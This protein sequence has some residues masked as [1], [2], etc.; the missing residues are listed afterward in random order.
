MNPT[1]KI[2]SRDAA[3]LL[4]GLV[5]VNVAQHQRHIDKGGDPF[6]VIKAI[7]K[8]DIRYKRADPREH[9]QSYAE[10]LKIIRSGEG[11]AD[12]ED[13]SAAVVAELQHAGIRAR[14]YVY[15][16]RK[17][18][19]HVVVKTDRWGF[20]DPSVSAGMRKV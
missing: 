1:F 3:H 11:G 8:G 20:L 13:L 16:A 10:L 4:N 5:A 6:A 2:S 14:T 9:W 12:C 19:Y 18:L 7:Q 15:K 17:G